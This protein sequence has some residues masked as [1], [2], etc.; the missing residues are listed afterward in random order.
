M[1]GRVDPFGAFNFLVEITGVTQAAFM[2]VTGLEAEVVPIEYREGADK[3]LGSR[4]LPGLV[5]YSN[6]VL[7]RGITLDHSLWDW[8]KQG[9][10]G[11]VQ[12][13][14]MVVTLLDDQRQPVV[15]WA[16][17]EAWPC[18]Y[19]GPA[20]NAKGNEVAIETLEIC[21]EGLELVE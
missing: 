17:H 3:T 16:V 20:L 19:E 15:R 8:F 1:A 7:K 10:N 18:K 9:L 11:K 13:A 4:K 6:I 21:H 2:E 5:K 12:R 14:N